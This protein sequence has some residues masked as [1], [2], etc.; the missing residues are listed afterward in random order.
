[1][2]M[3]PSA[4]ATEVKQDWFVVDATNLPVGRLSSEIA[5][6]LM[7]KHK[8][9]YTAHVDTGDHI[10]VI[11]AEKVRLTGRKAQQSKFFWHTG[12]PGGIKDITPAKTLESAHP[13]RVIERG[14]QRMLPKGTMGRDMF[15]KL[16]VYAGTQHAHTAQQPAALDLAK[17]IAKK[18][19]K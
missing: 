13:H 16:H 18:N 17:V 7:G 14:V 5:K 11:N 2:K 3:T 8:P 9:T 1:M 10:V 19:V 4:K 12:H 15:R 6:R